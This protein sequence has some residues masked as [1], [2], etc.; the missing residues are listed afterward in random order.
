MELAV[1][2]ADRFRARLEADGMDLR[3]DRLEVLQINVGRLCNQTCQHCHVD[4]GPYRRE[5]MTRTTMDRIL[6]WAAAAQVRMVDIT[7]G[8]PE[9][10]PHFEHLVERCRELGAHVID[11]CNLTVLLEPGR[12][13]L[14]DFFRRH[15]VELAC[16]LPCYLEDNVDRQRGSG[17]FRRSIEA[18]RRLNAV[19]YGRPGTGLVLD[20]VYNPQGTS[21][22]PPQK[23]LE[24][25]YRRELRARYG[26]EFN[27]LWT[28]TNM[29]ISRFA[30]Y[31]VQKGLLDEY[32]RKLE[33]AHN[34][35]TVPHVMCR[36]TLSVDWQGRVY[37][38]DFNQML[39]LPTGNGAAHRYL[40]D[41]DPTELGDLPI[42][43]GTHC[44]GC[45]AGSGSSCAGSLT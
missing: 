9:M 44:F 1:L 13:H 32:L 16:S 19:G 8:A 22:P 2:P 15:G 20:L 21:L 36:R 11:R 34:P 6:A 24:E 10:N 30:R 12:E 23:P 41:I 42:R 29:P 27:H 7:G 4:A 28:I 5:I 18:L 14:P 45:T 40:W 43:T 26:I 37:D 39:D 25:A 31:L 17:V 38:C 3:R 35:Q 33:Q